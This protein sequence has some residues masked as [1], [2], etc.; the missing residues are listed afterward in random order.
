MDTFCIKTPEQFS[1]SWQPIHWQ[2]LII[3]SGD[4][5]KSRLIYDSLSSNNHWSIYMTTYSSLATCQALIVGFLSILIKQTHMGDGKT[6]LWW[7]FAVG[8]SWAG[9]P[10]LWLKDK[11][12]KLK[13]AWILWCGRKCAMLWWI[14]T[15]FWQNVLYKVLKNSPIRV[16]INRKTM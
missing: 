16:K 6:S 13:R 15:V 8:P 9:I 3:G 14:L 12:K 11:T 7:G 1:K 5:P 2:T 10:I 4:V